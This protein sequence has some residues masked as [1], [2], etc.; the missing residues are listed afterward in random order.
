M[1]D[2]RPITP[3]SPT[4]SRLLRSDHLPHF[5]AWLGPAL[6]ELG[7]IGTVRRLR[8]VVD[9]NVVVQDVVYLA[10]RAGV[11]DFRTAFQE[12]VASQVVEPFA[13]PRLLDE[14]ESKIP[15]VAR[16]QK[17]AV[18]DALKVWAEYKKVI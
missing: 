14:V 7:D 11:P 1:P 2:G 3:E 13:P 6:S 18:D 9:T 16:H 5:A 8:V 4:A 12:L 17:V 10:K 15:K